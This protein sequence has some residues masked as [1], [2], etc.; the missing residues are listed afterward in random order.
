MDVTGQTSQQ[1]LLGTLVFRLHGR[2]HRLDAVGEGTNKLFI[3]F[4][5]ETNV[6]QTY[7]SGRFLYAD[8]PGADGLTTVDFNQSIN[9]PC[10]FTPF[11]TC[12]LPP[13][14]NR[15]AVAVRAGEKRYGPH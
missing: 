2:T 9:P 13:K 10:A 3:L 8:L 15:L 5:D 14:Q 6:T 12:P 4:A 1:P 7:G 11:A